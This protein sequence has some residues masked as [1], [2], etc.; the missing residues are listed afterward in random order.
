MCNMEHQ[1]LQIQIVTKDFQFYFFLFS[2]ATDAT[3][4]YF[5]VS[6]HSFTGSV[7]NVKLQ[8]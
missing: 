8:M 3:A 5:F 2:K 6:K 4:I 1:S 7:V